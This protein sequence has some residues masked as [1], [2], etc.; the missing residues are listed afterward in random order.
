MTQKKKGAMMKLF[1]SARIPEQLLPP[2][3]EAYEVQYH[4]SLLPLSKEEL[5]AHVKDADALL[6]PLSDKID[7]E[8]LRASHLKIVA[9]YG[10]GFD[11]VNIDA[12]KDLGIAVTNAPAPSSAVSTAELTFGLILDALRHISSGDRLT[13]RGEFTGWRPTF[14]LGDQLQGKTLGIFGLGRIGR[15]LAQRAEAFGMKILYT[16]RSLKETP[17]TWH[18]VDFETLLKESDVLSLHAAYTKDLHHLIDEKA[19]S[20]MKPSAVL[21]NAARGPMVSE[22]ALIKALE[23]KTI[24]A[25]ALDV[26]EF[27]PKVS[28]KLLS[29]ENVTLVPHLGN[30]TLEARLEMGRAAVE[31]LLAFSKGQSL[32]NQ[33]N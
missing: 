3:Q 14:G 22:E 30:A 13:R 18:A 16:S 29:M 24:K 15:N 17:K 11:N 32:P 7:E 27:E 31:N 5:I 23:E 8:I 20:Q 19:L 4:D 21:I 6:C 9:N 26:Y 25:A 2:L 33:V 28:E 1:I 10:A 12:A